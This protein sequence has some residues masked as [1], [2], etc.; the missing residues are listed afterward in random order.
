MVGEWMGSE[1][2][3]MAT[4]V[5]KGE[6]RKFSVHALTTCLITTSSVVPSHSRSL[7]FLPH[8]PSPFVLFSFVSRRAL[9]GGQT[10]LTKNEPAMDF[11]VRNES[12]SR[13]TVAIIAPGTSLYPKFP[14]PSR[15]LPT[16][17]LAQP[18][19]DEDASEDELIF[20][21]ER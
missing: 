17:L 8:Q 10:H 3:H 4:E 13:S 16:S 14:H 15:T 11:K 18:C 20:Q 21:P 7:F 19:P 2:M 5:T 1:G 12:F 9:A 6:V